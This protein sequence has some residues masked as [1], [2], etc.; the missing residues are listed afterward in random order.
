MSRREA[1]T[2]PAE[3]EDAQGFYVY[4]VGADDALAP[5]F[6]ADVPGAIEDGRGLVLVEAGGLAAV[7]SRVPLSDYGEDALASRLTDATWTATRAIRHERVVEHFARRVAVV[8]LRFGTIYLRRES[9]AGMLAE[10]GA[11]LRAGLARLDGREEWGLNVYV[12]RA[13]LREEVTRVSARLRELSARAES[14]PPGQAYLLRKKI[15]AMREEEARAETKR[16]AFEIEDALADA[17]DGASRLRVLKDEATA[18]GE[19]AARLAFLVARAR[20]D[21]FR[22]AAERLAEEH[23]PLGFSFELTGPWP[24]YNFVVEDDDEGKR[25]KAKGKNQK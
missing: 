17:C 7:V 2:K 19:L 3:G 8:P 5:L 12:E 18:Q 24:A 16:I 13:R 22:E 4:C 6:D 1:E 10:R 11:Q 14:S 25:Q 21:E 20:F 15:E 9:V 23:V